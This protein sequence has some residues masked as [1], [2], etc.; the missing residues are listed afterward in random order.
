MSLSD[1]S[2][3]SPLLARTQEQETLTLAVLAR[4]V[5]L[6]HEGTAAQ[7]KID[8]G[9]DDITEFRA[10]RR[11]VTRGE[12]AKEKLILIAMPLI[13]SLAHKE[14]RRRQAWSSRVTLEDII[15]EGIGGFLRGINAYNPQGDHKSPTN[16]LGQWIV[17]DMRRNVEALEHDFSVPYEAMERQRKIRAIRSRLASELG[18]EPTDEE[19]IEAANTPGGYGDNM[20]GRADKKSK[21]A[22]A[23][24]RRRLITQKH[25]DEEREMARRTGALTPM[26]LGSEDS[27]AFSATDLHS[28]RSITDEQ[29]Q[30]HESIASIEQAE[31]RQ[32]LAQ[33]IEDA[34]SL[35]G[36]GEPQRD[37]IR[38]KYGL[39]PYEEEQTLKVIALSTSV[40]KHKITKIVN[41]FTREMTTPH[42]AFHELVSRMDE[43]HVDAIGMG[44]I[45]STLG[46]FDPTVPRKRPHNDLV[47]GHSLDDRVDVVQPTVIGDSHRSGVTATFECPFGDPDVRRVYPNEERTPATIKCPRC[48]KVIARVA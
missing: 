1:Q 20:L 17:T 38:R 31:S 48:Q 18:H 23:T 12:R 7:A 11:T 10:L 24:P 16:Y 42:G 34:F 44:W 13:R 5:P 33:L 37:I 30:Q 43:D 8:A 14:F 21:P 47:N 40:P 19:I 36:I 46:E 32:A 2:Y 22:T 3:V 9:V 26:E 28:A 45:T 6:V 15:S 27:E 39:S 25:L 35:I 41:L 29:G 4:E